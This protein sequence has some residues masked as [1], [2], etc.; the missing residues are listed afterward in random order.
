MTHCWGLPGWLASCW[1]MEAELRETFKPFRQKE[2]KSHAMWSGTCKHGLMTHCWGL[3]GW[4]ASC[5]LMEAD[6]P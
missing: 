1:L 5:W 4:L 6:L 3:P 2:M